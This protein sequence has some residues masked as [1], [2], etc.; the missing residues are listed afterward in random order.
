MGISTFK[1][2]I[3]YFS[4][5]FFHFSLEGEGELKPVIHLSGSAPAQWIL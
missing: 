2:R 4:L 3:S 5:F 1:Y